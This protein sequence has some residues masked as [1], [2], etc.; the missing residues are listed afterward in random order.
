MFQL[1]S[2]ESSSEAVKRVIGEKI[3]ETITL[4]TDSTIDQ[5]T[6]VH[7]S[8]K[9]M[10][11][12]RA[13]LRLVRKDIGEMVFGRE[14]AWYRDAARQLA[15]MR[16]GAVMI[17]TFDLIQAEYAN[18][19]RAYSSDKIRQHLVTQQ[20]ERRRQF[21]AQSE[22]I[23][24]VLKTLT[25]AKKR[26]T[27]LPISYQDFSA[28]EKSLQQVYWRGRKRMNLAYQDGTDPEKFH[29][30]RKRVKYLWHQIE[31]LQSLWPKIFEPLADELHQLSDYLGEAHDLAVLED[32]L[33]E[34]SAL[35]SNSQTQS[36]FLSTLSTKRQTLEYTA[37]PLGKRLYA[38][39]SAVFV[40]RIATYWH[41]WKQN[42]PTLL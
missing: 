23:H 16:D 4:L 37:Q 21:L 25:D 17:E 8:R 30:W 40:N 5:D 36:L 15:P 20:V 22:I 6:A 29:D 3:S 19:L 35:F 2:E 42:K 18:I 32:Y 9:N 24:G 41:I 7:K 34:N 38:E 11:R 28:Y 33:K 12:I 39:K 14:N 1:K 31:F 13:L 26:V 27:S 10:K